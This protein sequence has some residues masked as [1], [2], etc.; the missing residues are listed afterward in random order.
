ADWTR[1]VDSTGHSFSPVPTI[2]VWLI[3]LVCIIVSVRANDKI[4]QFV[5]SRGAR[6]ARLFGLVTYPFYLLH[7]R[8]GDAIL[9]RLHSHIPDI[10]SFILVVAL[11]LAL[12]FVI[13]LYLE[14]PI[15]EQF[16]RLLHG[17]P[18]NSPTPAATLP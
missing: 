1:V 12:S 17:R 16:R 5:G 10:V 6:A 18:K 13:V 9:I 3:S 11:F 14:K 8:A 15:Q 2:I 4:A 7:Q